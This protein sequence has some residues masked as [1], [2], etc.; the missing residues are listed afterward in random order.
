M[1]TAQ[2]R[3]LLPDSHPLL[4]PLGLS[5]LSLPH[6][7]I[8]ASLHVVAPPGR[9]SVLLAPKADRL[10]QPPAH[11]QRPLVTQR[12]HRI[13]PLFSRLRQGIKDAFAP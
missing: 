9:P 2:L 6:A 4:T 11:C 12:S 13:T 1:R 8:S 5:E 7:G 10:A 3:L